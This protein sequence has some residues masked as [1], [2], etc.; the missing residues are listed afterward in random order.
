MSHDIDRDAMNALTKTTPASSPRHAP[1]VPGCLDG[2]AMDMLRNIR[3]AQLPQRVKNL[4][5]WLHEQTYGPEAQAR[6]ASGDPA[7]HWVEVNLRV[8]AAEEHDYP[9]NLSVRLRQLV[10][11]G[12]LREGK[13]GA[14]KTLCLT[15]SA[16]WPDA[17]FDRE[18]AKEL[19]ARTGAGAPP[20][21]REPMPEVPLAERT[22]D[23]RGRAW[24][25]RD[26]LKTDD[27]WLF[28]KHFQDA[29]DEAFQPLWLP[30]LRSLIDTYGVDV[31]VMSLTNV[32]QFYLTRDGQPPRY[33]WGVFLKDVQEKAPRGRVTPAIR[34]GGLPYATAATAHRSAEADA[35]SRRPATPAAA[36]AAGGYLARTAARSKSRLLALA[37]ELGI[38]GDGDA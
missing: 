1:L 32:L 26:A 6:Y 29:A 36:G 16:T 14:N 5:L 33:P 30:S 35:S 38:E 8:L 12:V 2:G 25:T 22:S 4:L 19:H 9:A 24:L 3:R 31:L 21:V 10:T 27:E 17:I 15:F 11:A 23:R 34:G 18:R 13:R 20:D 28:V 7:W 37:D